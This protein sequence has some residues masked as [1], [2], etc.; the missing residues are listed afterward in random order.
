M[1]IAIFSL[2]AWN[3]ARQR[4]QV[5]AEELAK[6]GHQVFYVE[7]ADL[8]AGPEEWVERSL[9][10]PAEPLAYELMPSL[11]VLRG[12]MIPPFRDYA[13]LLHYN[14]KLAPIT[15]LMCRNLDLDFAV[16][17]ATEYASPIL[18]LDIPFAYDHVDDT[19]H[20][21]A[22]LPD[23]FIRDMEILRSSSAFNMYIQRPAMKADPKGVFVPNGADA[24]EF[25][26]V[27]GPKQFDAVALSTIATWFDIDS[28]LASDKH[29]LLVGPMDHDGANNRQRFFAERRPGLIWVPRVD[30]ALANLWLSRAHVGLVPFNTAHPVVS[31]AIPVK[32]LEYFLAG[33]PVVTYRNAGIQDLYGDRVTYYSSRGG[34]DPA[35]DEAIELAKS[36]SS[37]ERIT[38]RE[39]ALQFQWKD[40]VSNVAERIQGSVGKA[41]PLKNRGSA[42]A[43]VGGL[44]ERSGSRG[45][46]ATA[47]TSDSACSLPTTE[48]KSGVTQRELDAVRRQHAEIQWV[49]DQRT[50]W[51]QKLNK[52]LQQATQQLSWAEAELRRLQ[53]ELGRLAA[54]NEAIKTTLNFRLF[55]WLGNLVRKLKQRN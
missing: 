53:P 11:H 30:K 31:Y 47:T 23:V 38:L 28:V 2:I 39:F 16:V 15:A 48:C 37:A 50:L 1:R 34:A 19:Q 6:L 43:D 22:V 29:I 25:F 26:P 32:I 20:M 54:E 27:E 21:D 3:F 52:D 41:I 8:S 5:F 45:P 4:P 33:L 55:C 18:D 49:L 7:P 35:L 44:P 51:A 36:M 40:I 12:R 24:G 13:R 46:A 10:E 14:E 17:L 42:T 9:K